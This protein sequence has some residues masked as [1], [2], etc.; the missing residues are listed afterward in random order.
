MPG[1][2]DEFSEKGVA[3]PGCI[4]SCFPY[5]HSQKL[6]I[7]L[8]VG[9]VNIVMGADKMSVKRQSAGVIFLHTI[10]VKSQAVDRIPGTLRGD[11]WISGFSTFPLA[12]IL[13]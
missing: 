10:E 12:N 7:G 3:L 11:C 9:S 13:S 6:E 1:P 8:H 5:S 2:K 4:S